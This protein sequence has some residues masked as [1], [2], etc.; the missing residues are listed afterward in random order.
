M[1]RGTKRTPGGAAGAH[2]G[3]V[4]PRRARDPQLRVLDPAP[5]LEQ[6]V[7]AL[8]RAHQPEAE[9]DWLIGLERCRLRTGSRKLSVAPSRTRGEM[10]ENAV[11]DHV[12]P[13]RVDAQLVGQSLAAVLGVHDDRVEALVQPPLRGALARL[14][15]AREDVVRGQHQRR[16][17]GPRGSR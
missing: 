3:D 15:L 17:P 9:D 13:R 6:Q 8:V 14:G 10:L 4:H 12:H 5:S 7:D 16:P 11:R 2:R 1:K